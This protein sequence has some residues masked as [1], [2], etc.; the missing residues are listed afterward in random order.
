[1]NQRVNL[2]LPEHQRQYAAPSSIDAEVPATMESGVRAA[3]ADRHFQHRETLFR[4]LISYDEESML[5][6]IELSSK[7]R[8]RRFHGAYRS[9]AAAELSL[10]SLG[11]SRLEP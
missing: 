4:A 9:L 2:T 5:W 1:M 3:N 7:G 11:F 6:L 10:Q 8:E